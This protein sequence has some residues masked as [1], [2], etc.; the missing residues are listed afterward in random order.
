MTL[1]L[2]YFMSIIDIY[3]YVYEIFNTLLLFSKLCITIYKLSTH[4]YDRTGKCYYEQDFQKAIIKSCGM[5][6][7]I[8]NR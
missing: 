2:I 5:E 1:K 3:C 4:N 7:E 8:I 6:V